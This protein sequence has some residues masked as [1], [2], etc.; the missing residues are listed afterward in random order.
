MYKNCTFPSF[1]LIS[2][3]VIGKLYDLKI[4]KAELKLIRFTWISKD[5]YQTK[6]II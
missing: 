2:I 4:I 5:S 6:N 3:K 1:S